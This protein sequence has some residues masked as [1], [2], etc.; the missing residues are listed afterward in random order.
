M[1]RLGLIPAG[2]PPHSYLAPVYQ[3]GL[4]YLH[5]Q[6]HG[7]ALAGETAKARIVQL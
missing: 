6:K 3:R 5:L 1:I 7:L 4:A 2:L